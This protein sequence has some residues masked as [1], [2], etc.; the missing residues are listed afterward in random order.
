MLAGK[1]RV[2]QKTFNNALILI[3]FNNSSSLTLQSYF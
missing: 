3:A 2:V 1:P